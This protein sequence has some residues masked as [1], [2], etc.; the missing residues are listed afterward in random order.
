MDDRGTKFIILALRPVKT[1]SNDGWREVERHLR[2]RAQCAT[3]P[4][5]ES[6][7][8]SV[9]RPEMYKRI[10]VVGYMAGT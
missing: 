9:V 4:S 10:W 3:C 2:R 5:P 1:V 7:A 8:M 6:I